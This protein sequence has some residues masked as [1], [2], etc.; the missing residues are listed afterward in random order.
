M[1]AEMGTVYLIF[2]LLIAVIAVIFA[3][4]NTMTVTISFLAWEITGSLSLVLLVTLAIGAVI[5]L[6]V[7]TPSAIR[8]RIAVSR[9]RKRIGTLE[10]ELDEQKMRI[11]DLEKPKPVV[12]VSETP[13]RTPA[14]T[15]P[16]EP[17]QP[18]L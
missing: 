14:L 9:D 2:A 1:E 13:E 11:V 5:G 18:K 15:P 4:Q 16:A 8:S 3:L 17:P 12:P 10:K 7:L 6:L